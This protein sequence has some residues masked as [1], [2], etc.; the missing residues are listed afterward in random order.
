[1]FLWRQFLNA[2]K[3]VPVK[4]NQR[5]VALVSGFSPSIVKVVLG[6]DPKEFTPFGIMMKTLM[7][8]RYDC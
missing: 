6:A 3:N 4:S 2:H 5:G 8:N 7:S 1:M